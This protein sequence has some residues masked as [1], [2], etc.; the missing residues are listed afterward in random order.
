M[1]KTVDNLMTMVSVTP[2]EHEGM[3]FDALNVCVTY[4]K[5]TG[6]V[7][8]Y[9][10]VKR[11]EYGYQT[12]PMLSDD[13]LVKNTSVTVE[14]A[15][16]N[17]EKKLRQMMANI[18]VGQEAIAWLFD[19]REWEKLVRATGN[20]ARSGYPEHFK[21][22]MH[23]L[24]AQSES[25]AESKEDVSPMMK[26]NYKTMAKNKVK[27]RPAT[28]AE[29]EGRE[30][31]YMNGEQVHVMMIH[32]SETIGDSEAKLD[33]IMLTNMKKVQVEDLYV[34]DDGE[35]EPVEETPMMKQFRDLKSK[36]PDAVLLFRCGDFYETYEDDTKV[37]ADVLGITVTENKGVR[38]AGFPY[39]ALD[40]YLP[41][42]IRAGK[43]VAIC[44]QLEDPKL[45]K[46][47][48]KRGITE[49]LQTA[50]KN[51]NE[52][53]EDTTMKKNNNETN[54]VQTAQVNNDAIESVNVGEV[55]LDDI[56]PAMTEPK[57]KPVTMPLGKHGEMIIGKPKV[58]LRKKAKQAESG[59][60]PEAVGELAGMLAKVRLV[61]F[62]TKRG[63]TAPRIVGFSGEDDP[64]WKKHYDERIRQA[65][66]AKEARKKDAKAKVESS[67]FG[68]SRMMDYQT[69]TVVYCMTFGTRYMDV[70]KALCEAYNTSDRKAWEKAEQAVRDCKKGIVAGY[71]AEKAA[72]KA[73]REAKKQE[74]KGQ[75]AAPAMSSEEK[76][77]FDLFK[78]FMAG[79]KDAMAQ[80]N[81]VLKAA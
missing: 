42:L 70:A 77:M 75:P 79:D 78:R 27:Y 37:C 36:H 48:V 11:T 46:K 67:P 3:T 49:L 26:Q 61:T 81:D 68:A 40:T 44:D 33:Y 7:V 57:D 16:K 8:W 64:R 65:K 41:K 6:F 50:T 72:R 34:I 9:Q 24:M 29:I 1:A 51:N 66:A 73:E 43:R 21:K 55:S 58:T 10:P 17:S 59:P 30:D 80:V 12:G 4:R 76:A 15:S 31:L 35:P 56:R 71:Q 14:K 52:I 2:Y 54:N 53:S 47:L 32:R 18:E 63:D 22:Q 19:H 60:D 25:S 28:M 74:K 45:T 69:G 5:G 13:P 23:D 62:T 20:I 38:M 39:H